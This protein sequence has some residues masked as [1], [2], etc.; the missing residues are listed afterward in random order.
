MTQTT[1]PPAILGLAGSFFLLFSCLIIGIVFYHLEKVENNRLQAALEK[2]KE[3]EKDHKAQRD[4]DIEELG[5]LNKLLHT[6]GP[7]PSEGPPPSSP[8]PSIL[9]PSSM[10]IESGDLQLLM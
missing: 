7:P 9:P 6:S 8:P 1:T 4:K 2:C 10:S 5:R 3:E